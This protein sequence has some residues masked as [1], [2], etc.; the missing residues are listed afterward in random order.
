MEITSEI[1]GFEGKVYLPEGL[2]LPKVIAYSK[3]LDEVASKEG[4]KKWDRDEI[5]MPSVF[6]CID[7]MEIKNQ[8][9]HPTLDTFRFTPA[10]QADEFIS[11]IISHISLLV[12][13]EEEIPNG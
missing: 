8:P 13:G 10:K 6:A 2:S 12:M 5:M 7:K 11:L 3:A 4:I 1:K 9:Q